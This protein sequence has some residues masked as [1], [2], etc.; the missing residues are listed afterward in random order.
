VEASWTGELSGAVVTRFGH[1]AP[2]SRIEVMEAAHPVADAASEAAAR[3]ILNEVAGLTP[4]DLV[5]CL[6]WGG[7]S[8]LLEHPIS[9]GLLAVALVVLVLA[10]LAT[11]RKG[12]D[13]VFVQ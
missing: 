5:L 8:A 6:I 12:R 9:A 3:R 2:T 7:G 11:I 13:E 10:L 1:G 4:D